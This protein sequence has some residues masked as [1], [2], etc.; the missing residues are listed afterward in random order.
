MSHHRTR[1]ERY[2]DANRREAARAARGVRHGKMRPVLWAGVTEPG[3]E[4]YTRRQQEDL[5]RAEAM[6][7]KSEPASGRHD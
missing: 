4:D 7:R 5:D 3:A 1:A 2:D 6:M